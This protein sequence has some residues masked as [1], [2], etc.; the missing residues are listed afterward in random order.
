MSRWPELI[1]DAHGKLDEQAVLSIILGLGLLFLQ[2]FTVIFRKQPFDVV[3]F[4]EA[5]A[6][7][8]LGSP[9]G[10]GLRSMMERR[11]GVRD[12]EGSGNGNGS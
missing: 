3:A 12:G 10:L 4:G 2:V 8:T 9:A 6:M 1:E 11:F 5:A 7:F